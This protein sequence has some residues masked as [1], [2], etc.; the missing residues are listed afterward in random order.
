[1]K[2][3][4]VRETRSPAGASGGAGV[5]GGAGA[6]GVGAGAGEAGG[7]VGTLSPPQP[8]SAPR[9]SRVAAIRCNV[10][11][12]FQPAVGSARGAGCD[13][14]VGRTRDYI[15]NGHLITPNRREAGGRDES[16]DTVQR[17]VSGGR[18]RAGPPR[19]SDPGH[20]FGAAR[21]VQLSVAKNVQFPVAI[22][23][24]VIF[25]TGCYCS[26][27]ARAGRDDGP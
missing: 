14:L 7:A 1:M 4:A 18:S 5:G 9:R 22:E 17:L 13:D 2:S 21:S 8:A 20:G 23:S 16:S 11:V 27:P 26:A 10:E 19:E 25:S 12:L 6:V 3:V 15:C 24:R